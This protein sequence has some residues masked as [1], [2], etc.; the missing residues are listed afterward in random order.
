[1][2]F[3]VDLPG[4]NCELLN[5]IQVTKGI[6]VFLTMAR[7]IH[8]MPWPKFPVVPSSGGG[9]LQRRRKIIRL[10][11][12]GCANRPFFHVVITNVRET[13]LFSLLVDSH[14]VDDYKVDLLY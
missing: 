14:K 12:K 6:M 13:A 8:E 1:M 10:A 9:Y 5:L 4:Q 3:S 11:L 2:Q 7:R